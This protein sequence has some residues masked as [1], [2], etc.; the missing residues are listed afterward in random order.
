[1][2]DI[3]LQ[4]QPGQTLELD[5]GGGQQL[6][7]GTP[8]EESLSMQ[9]KNGRSFMLD[10]SKDKRINLG[11]IPVPSRN[12]IE[13]R[14]NT[15]AYWNSMPDF[16]PKRGM[17]IVYTDSGQTPDG[18]DVPGIKFG[19]GSAYLIDIPFVNEDM[20][21][22]LERLLNQHILNSDVHVTPAEKAFWNNKL[23]CA[24]NDG[25]LILNRL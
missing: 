21:L 22:E 16:V 1:M 24:V 2:Q 19:D 8:A 14:M 11:A 18:R 10:V 20:T 23:N 17:M 5:L 7:L 13:V 3:S 25:T 4:L 12:M 9:L 6:D 15:T